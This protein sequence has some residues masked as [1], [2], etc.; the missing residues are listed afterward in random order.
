MTPI[1]SLQYKDHHHLTSPSW[2]T[3]LW[4]FISFANIQLQSRDTP[5]LSPQRENDE[6]IMDAIRQTNSF[7]KNEESRIN[8]VRCHLEA[9]TM[10]DIVTGNG[11]Q[12]CP[13]AY[14]GIKPETPSKFDWHE[15]RPTKSD[16][17]LWQRA[18]NHLLSPQGTLQLPLGKWLVAPHREWT[19]FHC[20]RTDRIMQKVKGGWKPYIRS[21][22][23]TR[24]KPLF[25]TSHGVIPNDTPL[26]LT[27]VTQCSESV[28][29]YEGINDESTQLGKDNMVIFRLY[30]IGFLLIATF[31]SMLS[32]NGYVRAFKRATYW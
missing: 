3:S 30:H 27:T 22:N 5:N 23:A 14:K 10:A 26:H 25:I 13:N 24:N 7:T 16:I 1:L 17:I 28:V 12:I 19:W 4:E 32:Q 31:N 2:L 21:I 15:E 18:L 11:K 29:A 20:Q 8:R 9:F 6:A